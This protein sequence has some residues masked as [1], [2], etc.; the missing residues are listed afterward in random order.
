MRGADW[1]YNVKQGQGLLGD[2]HSLCS[3]QFEVSDER[4]RESQDLITWGGFWLEPKGEIEKS[5]RGTAFL[6]IFF[7]AVCPSASAGDSSGKVDV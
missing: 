1:Q 3:A 2:R 4:K 7:G 5:W 6:A